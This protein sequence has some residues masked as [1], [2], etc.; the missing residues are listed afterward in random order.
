MDLKMKNNVID[1]EGNLRANSYQND[2]KCRLNNDM[3]SY[4]A[5][6]DLLYR[7][8]VMNTIPLLASQ[9]I[10]DFNQKNIIFD[11]NR[12]YCLQFF[13]ST[14]DDVEKSTNIN[15]KFWKFGLFYGQVLGIYNDNSSINYQNQNTMQKQTFTVSIKLWEF[16]KLNYLYVVQSDSILFSE[17]QWLWFD[18]LV[19]SRVI[20]RKENWSVRYKDDTFKI[21]KMS[22]AYDSN[23]DRMAI[24]RSL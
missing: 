19:Y 5:T 12:K 23:Y 18:K 4:K 8:E 1:F 14:E 7:D 15:D 21:I 6:K 22:N 24:F 11:M 10:D 17:F 16:M 2:L 9:K 13:A 20:N 3:K